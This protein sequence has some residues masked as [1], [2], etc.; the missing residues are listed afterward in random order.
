MMNGAV[1]DGEQ[2]TEPRAVVVVVILGSA[3]LRNPSPIS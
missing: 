1:D 2:E 3:A